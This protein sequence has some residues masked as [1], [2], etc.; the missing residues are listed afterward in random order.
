[1][2]ISAFSGIVKV[3][4]TPIQAPPWSWVKGWGGL[5]RIYFLEVLFRIEINSL[6]PKLRLIGVVGEKSL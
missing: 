4:L 3:R 2:I 6:D 5:W 1:M